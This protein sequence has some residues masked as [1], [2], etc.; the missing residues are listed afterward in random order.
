MGLFLKIDMWLK[1][2]LDAIRDMATLVAGDISIFEIQ[3]ATWGSLAKSPNL[4]V[5]VTLSQG[6]GH[7]NLVT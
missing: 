2:I 6:T 5:L 7:R 3:I 4:A 1:S